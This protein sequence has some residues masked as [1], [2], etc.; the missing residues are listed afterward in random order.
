MNLIIYFLIC[1]IGI[2]AGGLIN[3][4]AD[5]LPERNNPQRPHY[6]DGTPRPVS[7]WLGITA[8]LMRQRTSATGSRLSWRHPLTEIGT[9]LLMLLTA[10]M[11]GNDPEVSSIQLVFYLIYMAIFALVTVI[12][13]EH[14]LILFIV[15]IPSSAL[16]IL[17][18]I[19]TPA[20]SKPDL[21]DA[22]LGGLL[23]FGVFFM[24][25][26]GGVLFSYVVAK[27]Q[28]YELPEVAF[29]YGDVMLS[30]LCGLI[31]GW[32]PLIFA[33]FI[34]VFAGAFGALIYLLVRNF[35][36]RYDMFTPLP[37][38]PYI[39]LGTLVML[40]FTEQVRAFS[41]SLL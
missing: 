27:L 12:D 16:A 15:I 2:L 17:D 33:M 35:S 8:F 19:I 5:D 13:L 38:G 11:M 30:T 9:A 28:G 26:L 18:A 25:Y 36:G 6:P 37:Y 32:Q 39:V 41:F 20:Q 14:R 31:L 3:V 34:T 4:L 21:R 22:L 10:V 29:G 1:V 40:L 24:L 23:G 7:A